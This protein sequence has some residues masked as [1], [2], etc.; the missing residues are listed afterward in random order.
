MGASSHTF[1]RITSV[2]ISLTV[3]IS[4]CATP[5]AA[6]ADA[7][8]SQPTGN[9]S[10]TLSPTPIPPAATPTVSL[11]VGRQTPIPKTTS[12]IASSNVTQIVEVARYYGDIDYT[13]KLSEDH[14]FLFVLDHMGVTKYDYST[15]EYLGFVPVPNQTLDFQISSDGTWWL[16]QDSPDSYLVSTADSLVNPEIYILGDYIETPY[17]MNLSP[18][19][20]ML[21]ATLAT[22]WGRTD[23]ISTEDFRVLFSFFGSWPG[24]AAFSYDG[25]FF[26]QANYIDGGGGGSVEVYDLN[27]FSRAVSLTVRY[28]FAVSALAFSHDSSSLAI[29]EVEG[30]AIYSLPEGALQA[31]ITDLCPRWWSGAQVGFSH[32]SSDIVFESSQCSAGRWQL[33]SE[34]SKLTDGSYFSFTRSVYASDGR[35]IYIPYPK[36]IEDSFKPYD[37]TDGFLYPDWFAFTDNNSIAFDTAKVEGQIFFG[38]YHCDVEIQGG[39]IGCEPYNPISNRQL[40]NTRIVGLDRKIYNIVQ[41]ET[42]VHL[43]SPGPD[44]QIL[45]SIPFVQDI[46]VK[47][48]D[49]TN[50]ILVYSTGS[51]TIIRN[52]ETDKILT[53]QKAIT[54]VVFSQDGR[55][56]ALCKYDGTGGSWQY[57]STGKIYIYDIQTASYIREVN[58]DCT[59]P[60]LA[61]SPDGSTLAIYNYYVKEPSL[62]VGYGQD[63]FNG[64][65]GYRVMFLN[66]VE[67]YKI[68]YTE[69]DI[70]F[71]HYFPRMDY[72]LAYS[73]DGSLLAIGCGKHEICFIDTTT[74]Q[75]S[76]RIDAQSRI[77]HLAFSPDGK[78]LATLSRWGTLSLFAIGNSD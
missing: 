51:D 71:G 2:L 11:P 59:L 76:H 36:S 52:I 38:G 10:A 41:E 75:I 78:L 33:T 30:L 25:R 64:A 6:L 7:P 68:N 19:G 29:R 50:Q 61:F 17:R 60:T 26:A 32:S 27:D 35:A 47:G 1:A 21:S 66:T 14:R 34:E 46:R 39:E 77:S 67:P 58:F 70:T 69:A 22:A 4:A 56:I 23:L 31:S 48:F 65:M 54:E 18:D 55:Y 24:S 40:G 13:V 57:R 73:S 63:F 49:P 45:Y 20:K 53:S 3:L 62:V 37:I 5:V 12:V 44:N 16:I 43:M 28:P 15:M 72:P 74:N 8:T 42:S 9:P